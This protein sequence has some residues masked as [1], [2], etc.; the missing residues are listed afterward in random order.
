M[1]RSQRVVTESSGGRYTATQTAGRT[2]DLVDVSVADIRRAFGPPSL[3]LIAFAERLQLLIASTPPAVRFVHLLMRDFF[4]V[5]RAIAQLGGDDLG[6]RRRA[7]GVLGLIA[8]PRGFE[9]LVVALADQDAAVRTRVLWALGELRD[10]AAIGPISELLERSKAGSARQSR[11]TSSPDAETVAF[12]GDDETALH[13]LTMSFGMRAL[14]R[15]G[16]DDAQRV[17]EDLLPR[18]RGQDPLLLMEWM[19]TLARFGVSGVPPLLWAVENDYF[20]QWAVEALGEI[21]D[22]SARDTLIAALD[23]ENI[24]DE[25]EEALGRI[26]DAKAVP[27]LASRLAKAWSEDG[28]GAL[29]SIGGS[30]GARALASLMADPDPSHRTMVAKALGHVRAPDAVST[31]IEAAKDPD[32]RVRCA[33]ADALEQLDYDRAR[34]ERLRPS[35]TDLVRALRNGDA[36]FRQAV[37]QLLGARLEP[38][39]A[40]ALVGL[41]VDPDADV[42]R[43][44][45]LSLARHRDPRAVRPLLELLFSES[46]KLAE[47]DP[48]IAWAL[49]LVGTPEAAD[50]LATALD[51][52]EDNQGSV[53]EGLI[54]IGPNAVAPLV[55]ILKATDPAFQVSIARVLVAIGPAAIADSVQLLDSPARSV[56]VEIL[57]ALGEPAEQAVL[58]LLTSHAA[59]E[60]EAAASVLQGVG[61]VRSLEPLVSLLA[62]TNMH[63]RTAATDALIAIGEPVADHLLAALA[64]DAHQVRAASARA[65]GEIGLHRAAET[66]IAALEDPD[67]G[68]RYQALIATAQVAG[69]VPGDDAQRLLADPDVVVRRMAAELLG[70]DGTTGLTDAETRELT[71]ALGQANRE[72]AAAAGAMLAVAGEVAAL[73]QVVLDPDPLARDAA[74]AML[75]ADA[76]TIA[77]LR[78][79]QKGASR[80]HRFAIAQLLASLGDPKAINA[81]VASLDEDSLAPGDATASILLDVADASVPVL[82]RRMTDTTR[83]HVYAELIAR[84]GAIAVDHLI[85]Q[86]IGHDVEKRTIAGDLLARI[87]RPAVGPLIEILGNGGKEL[88]ARLRATGALANIDHP[89][90]SAALAAVADAHASYTS[91]LYPIALRLAAVDALSRS[92]NELATAGLRRALVSPE[93]KVRSAA[94]RRLRGKA[95][96]Q[97]SRSDVIS[98]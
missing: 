15:I 11:T 41:F 19:S 84:S 56:A 93:R 57:K 39:V 55:S 46:S 36:S 47:V 68:V 85:A 67:S 7:A 94:E 4:A 48:S 78:A 60:R 16:G 65:L 72:L 6:A 32:I 10:P 86:L 63:V 12:L 95:T 2:V 75:S 76:E 35:S 33:A 52:S 38:G 64:D 30:D 82:V 83:G 49:G 54:R 77:A 89:R 31:L 66:L 22:A 1:D 91:W 28:V 24:A 13:A 18:L 29:A 70:T 87:G 58:P 37:A 3:E 43:A 61:T 25:V 79:L 14:A 20:A 80:E 92:M 62:D 97:A 90:A 44:A 8:D 74:R 88:E 45:M 23:D 73:V 40:D 26:G 81:L 69:F 51:E 53:V 21:G 9:P 42:R 27:A 34:V 96:P 98:H 5:P 59:A 17:V 50:A 71:I